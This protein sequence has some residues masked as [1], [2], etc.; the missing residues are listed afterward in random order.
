MKKLHLATLATKRI[1]FDSW[2]RVPLDSLRHFT[3]DDASA[4]VNFDFVSK[5]KTFSES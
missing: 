3:F 1:F 4:C 2:D 5:V